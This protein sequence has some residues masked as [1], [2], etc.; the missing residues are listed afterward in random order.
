MD[1]NIIYITY[2]NGLGHMTVVLDK[3]F[4]T[5]ATRV[6]KLLK[7][8][9]EDYEHRDELRAAI[10]QHCG[11]RAQELLDS[12]KF[13]ANRAVD[14]HTRATELQPEID[15]LTRQV[16]SMEAYC[17][18]RSGR[19]YREKLKELKARQKEM[20][21]QRRFY[22]Q[23]FKEYQREFASAE[24]KAERLKKNAEVANP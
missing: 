15:K 16:E 5:D 1:Q 9:D 24:K 8:I 18:T 14:M 7:V 13:L 19:C 22:L 17:K 10:V 2:H 20:T 4:P 6:R 11:Q 23:K 12:R 21:A 3:F